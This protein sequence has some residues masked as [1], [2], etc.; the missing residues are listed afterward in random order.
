MISRTISASARQIKAPRGPT[1]LS[2]SRPL[3]RRSPF[4]RGPRPG[5]NQGSAPRRVCH[6]SA[7]GRLAPELAGGRSDVVAE[8]RRE[9]ALAGTPDLE[10]DVREARAAIGEQLHGL[11]DAAA[12][13]VAVRGD[14]GRE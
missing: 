10:S 12:D 14:P 11:P 2:P 6:R 3:I 7:T 8:E 1:Y 9:V 13:D 5:G 4:R